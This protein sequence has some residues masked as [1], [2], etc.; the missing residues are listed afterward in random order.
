MALTTDPNV[1][2]V[3]KGRIVERHVVGTTISLVLMEC[4]QAPVVYQVVH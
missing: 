3:I 4:H 1:D 2:E